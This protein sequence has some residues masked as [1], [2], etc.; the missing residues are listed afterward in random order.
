[1]FTVIAFDVSPTLAVAVGTAAGM[2]AMTKLLIAPLLFAGL[3]VGSVGVDAVPA[4]VLAT[5]GGLG[6]DD[7]PRAT[8]SCT[9]TPTRPQPPA[10]GEISARRSG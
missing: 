2:S 10:G 5:T 3:L 4:A 7:R 8:A 1:M 6:R 9:A